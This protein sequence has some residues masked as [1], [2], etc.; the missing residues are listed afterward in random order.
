MLLKISLLF[1]GGALI[2]FSLLRCFLQKN[3]EE[4]EMSKIADLIKLG[5]NSCINTQFYALL[6]V[7]FAM[8]LCKMFFN[9]SFIPEGIFGLSHG[10]GIAMICVSF[11]LYVSMRWNLL[12]AI[13][14]REG[15]AAGFNKAFESGKIISIFLLGIC[16]YSTYVILFYYPNSAEK[17][18]LA[19]SIGC[20]I[21]SAFL[22]ISG[23]IF[24][25]A[26]DVVADLVGKVFNDMPEDDPKNP[27]V[28]A[29]NIG[30][31]VGDGSGTAC[32]IFTSYIT[33]FTSILLLQKTLSKEV[34][35]A[36]CCSA[37]ASLVAVGFT[38]MNEISIEEASNKILS[39]VNR[40]L[41]SSVL[42]SA[43]FAII[44]KGI[45]I[46]TSK[47]CF[48]IGKISQAILTDTLFFIPFL[49]G[50]F[51]IPIGMGITTYY[52]SRGCTPVKNM[53]NSCETGGAAMNLIYG[54]SYSLEAAFVTGISFSLLLLALSIFSGPDGIL[55]AL[56]GILG[57][58]PSIM[59]MD[60]YGP[61]C[62]NA[63][64]IA[65]MSNSDPIIRENTDELDSIGN[66]VKA[67][68]KSYISIVAIMTTFVLLKICIA[69]IPN[70]S[71]ISIADPVSLIGLF[72]GISTPF[73]FSGLA[74][75]AVSNAAEYIFPTVTQTIESGN[76]E[77]NQYYSGPIRMLTIK[78]LQ[79]SVMPILA[80]FF[81]IFV[82]LGFFFIGLKTT[83]FTY[84][85]F[86]LIGNSFSSILLSI[87]MTIGGGA[88]DNAKKLV[89]SKFPKGHD[90]RKAAVIGDTFGDPLKDTAGPSL[91]ASLRI[92][93]LFCLAFFRYASG[94]I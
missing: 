4:S 73:L 23:G 19:M 41:N 24:T 22:R 89:E 90:A 85:I 26:A 14:S 38:K 32:E 57:M 86:S 91:I 8:I 53:A 29:D 47:G 77:D 2:G 40:M 80:I 30:D 64:S 1:A 75:R 43:L 69:S 78:S 82:S 94:L 66:M 59:S 92:F 31:N 84:L 93:L 81:P 12:T 33:A 45:Q 28:I 56:A 27:A 11:S 87:C 58:I 42:F 16:I 5:A 7:L 60:A 10:M 15:V 18:A 49:I 51:A 9:Q 54:H 34:I 6:P 83:V 36:F 50:I 17:T 20:A 46:S 13:S 55:I 68:T 76:P 67:L 44:Y 79:S 37:A 48:C 74:M 61:V 21:T 65:T 71:Q 63:G 35:V 3:P 62:D 39:A 72:T 52:S 70:F 88:F 25:K